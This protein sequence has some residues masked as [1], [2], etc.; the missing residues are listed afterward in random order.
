M[1]SNIE[2]PGQNS[3]R[4]ADRPAPA[5]LVTLISCTVAVLLGGQIVQQ[6]CVGRGGGRNIGQYGANAFFRVT[7]QLSVVVTIQDLSR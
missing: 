6:C 1:Y 2:T 4:P 3:D 5:Q 7:I